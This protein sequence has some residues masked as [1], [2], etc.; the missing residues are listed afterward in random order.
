MI[1]FRLIE[2]NWSSVWRAHFHLRIHIKTVKVAVLSLTLSNFIQ[3]HCVIIN[4]WKSWKY[5]SILQTKLFCWHICFENLFVE[6]L[7]MMIIFFH[8]F[9]VIDNSCHLLPDITEKV[10][11]L[12]HCI[13][14]FWTISCNNNECLLAIKTWNIATV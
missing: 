13:Q 3:A 4:I 2:I 12:C 10:F 11:R 14:I 8:L 7:Y 5:V 1:K 6:Q 9:Q